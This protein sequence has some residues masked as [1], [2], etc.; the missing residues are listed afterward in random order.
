MHRALSTHLFVHHRLTTAM[1]QRILSAGVSAVEIFCAR[2][3]LDYFNRQQVNEIAS[4]LRDAPLRVHSVHL[5][6]FTDEHWGKGGPASIV[7]IANP[8][9]PKRIAAVDEVKRALDLADSFPF[10]F[11]VQH[12]GVGFDDEWSM[13]KVDAAFSSLEE[14]KSFGR[15]RGVEILVENIPNALSSAQKL[16][17]FFQLT[18]LNLGVC[19]D[20]GHANLMEGVEA[21]FELLEDRICSLHVHD[22]DGSKD[23]HL[24]PGF[25]KEGTVDW[26]RTMELLRRGAD[27]YPLLLELKEDPS[28]SDPLGKAIGVFDWLE[29]LS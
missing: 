11:A 17:E 19:F 25:H 20:V 21:A 6:M 4:F 22:N 16:N 9:K 18:H 26:K 13:R 23:K 12:L 24:F 28:M 1:L 10:R 7:D 2:Q 15:Q 27:K 14:L 29:N 8:S 5:P 3:H